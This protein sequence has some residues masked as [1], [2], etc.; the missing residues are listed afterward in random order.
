MIKHVIK[1]LVGHLKPAKVKTYFGR[2]MFVS[3]CH[4]Q[5]LAGPTKIDSYCFG[6]LAVNNKTACMR[7][8]EDHCFGS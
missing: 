2:Y 4:S 6:P 7:L 3:L 5:R 1:K 8:E